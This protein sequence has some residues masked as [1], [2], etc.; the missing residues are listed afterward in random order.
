[1]I[2]RKAHT[3]SRAGRNFRPK[4]VE[5]HAKELLRHPQVRKACLLSLP[6]KYLRPIMAGTKWEVLYQT[7]DIHSVYRI[8]SE[9]GTCCM[10]LKGMGVGFLARFG[11]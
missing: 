11:M 5:Y 6:V 2:A 8:Q 7:G 9:A 4:T 1:M 10:L 3:F